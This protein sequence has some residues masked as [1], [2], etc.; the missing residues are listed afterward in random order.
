MRTGLRGPNFPDNREF[1]REFLFFRPFS[2]ILVSKT[3]ANSVVCSKISYATEQ[4]IV[5]DLTGNYLERT[6]NFREGSA[7]RRPA[8]L[9][10]DMS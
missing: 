6:G 9:Q 5:S 1:N 4:G 10:A 3:Q 7:K 8:L 2:A